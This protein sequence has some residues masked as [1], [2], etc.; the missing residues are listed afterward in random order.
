[1]KKL[2]LLITMVCVNTLSMVPNVFH[3]TT[4]D[5][6]EDT[7][8]KNLLLESE[9]IKNS[10]ELDPQAGT[11][12]QNRLHIPLSKGEY[13]LLK[14][15][16]ENPDQFIELLQPLALLFKIADELN[17]KNLYDQSLKRLADVLL[18]AQNLKKFSENPDFLDSLGLSIQ[19]EDALAEYI[20]QM[21]RVRPALAK[22]TS[23]QALERTLQVN[24][25]AHLVAI[26]RDGTKII[27]NSDYDQSIKIWDIATGNLFNSLRT[28]NVV[29]SLAV[30]SDGT[31][32]ISTSSTTIDIWDLNT[33]S[34]LKA[35]GGHQGTV[36]YAII[37]KDGSKIISGLSNGT[38]NI[39][40]MSSGNLLNTLT[41]QGYITC[42]ALSLDE[43]KIISGSSDQTIKIWD[44]TTG[45]LLN[46]LNVNSGVKSIAITPDGQKIISGSAN[47]VKIWD[48]SSGNLLNTLLTS[49]DRI[50]AVAVT[51]NG[52]NIIA[53]SGDII[54]IWDLST[55]NLLKTFQNNQ[56]LY[57][58]AITPD[59]KKIVAGG[60]NGVT[61][62]VLDQPRLTLDEVLSIAV[63]GFMG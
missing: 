39:W 32:I 22:A 29:W 37:N 16:L 19:L 46:T 13:L 38:I 11:T 14:K 2:I 7:I 18:L 55:G 27:S 30:T 8:D 56:S 36:N 35:F 48:L 4:E 10:L 52:E 50:T 63:Q 54:D 44:I 33:G 15:H 40:D 61:I 26:T 51:P 43:S 28:P 20:A 57:A 17:F 49:K 34:L 5:E 24:N 42:L 62:W 25:P 53:A 23:Q 12:A 6:F 21:P 9:V 3:I 31:K 47:T 1:M 45:N 60:K 59:G 58:L 41:G